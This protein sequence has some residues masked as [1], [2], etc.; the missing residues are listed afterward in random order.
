MS[1]S[2]RHSIFEA[3]ANVTLGYFIMVGAQCVIFPAFGIH[4]AFHTN[5]KIGMSFLIV[6]LARSYAL[7]RLFN[8]FS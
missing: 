6:S 8:K 2:K 7:R 3:I 4:V 1:Q 5:L